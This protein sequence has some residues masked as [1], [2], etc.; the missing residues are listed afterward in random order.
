MGTYQDAF[1]RETRHSRQEAVNEFVSFNSEATK[2]VSIS[3]ENGR[4]EVELQKPLLVALAREN[5]GDTDSDWSDQEGSVDAI[6]DEALCDVTELALRTAGAPT[7]RVELYKLRA[8]LI[9]VAR[10]L[11]TY[12][13]LADYIKQYSTA[14]LEQFGLRGPR[15]QSTYRKAAKTLK[16]TDEFQTARDACF[17]AV[18]ALFW[19]GVP[20]P[21]TVL[22]RYQL[23]YD[24][25]PAAT[26]FTDG[27]RQLALYNL[28]EDLIRIVVEN[29]S[30]HREENKSRE[31][32]SLLGV[33]AYAAR[34]GE[35]I[36]D[37]ERTAHHA[38]DLRSALSGSMIWT[39]LNGLHRWKVG[40]MFDDANQALLEY[41]LGSGV[42]SE[43]VTASYDLT[44]VQSLGIGADGQ[45]FKTEDGR[46]R[47]ASLAFTDPD[48]DF[49]F[50]LRL[51]KSESQRARV[52]KNFLRNLTEMV[53]VKRFMLDRGFDGREDIEACHDFVPNSW[54]ICA[55]DDS[56]STGANSDYARLRADL[57]P[58]GTTVQ[59]N[60]GY[61]DLT[62]AVKLIGYSGADE[63]ADTPEPVRAFYTDMEIPEEKS[64]QDKLITN[65][66]FQYNQRAKIE[67][68]FRMAKNRFDPA[69]D[70]DKP[71]VKAFYF[72]MSVLLYN[73]Y[74]IVDT[75]P[76]PRAGVE[77]DTTQKEVLEVTHN[78][79]LNGPTIPEALTY[80]R[81]HR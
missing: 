20:V 11:S 28:V 17:V 36:T 53:E 1:A 42:V 14:Q 18:H 7:E 26:D 46:W 41:V 55:Q 61:A 76:S 29:L 81:E 63:Q 8:L 34:H 30:L 71:Q 58:G 22:N 13:D 68:I 45:A 27:A 79:A 64:K 35:S 80:H 23:D 49:S 65:I 78:L 60:A 31:L 52:L 51:L 62:P 72:Q 73:L 74:K 69:T 50:G 47:F 44:D 66:N 40:E 5:K 56:N 24:A 37:Y 15:E 67:P 57:E 16:T 32:R 3:I 19:N 54:V 10:G 4:K 38:F 77:I 39:H 6:F 21:Q 25:G 59:E 48:L 33:F 70:S 43:P 9:Q 12:E 75:V 2:A